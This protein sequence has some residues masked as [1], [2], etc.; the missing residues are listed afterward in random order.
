MLPIDRPVRITCDYR[1]IKELLRSTYI[2]QHKVASLRKG[3]SQY[4]KSLREIFLSYF[5]ISSLKN[6]FFCGEGM[7][8][9]NKP[10][11]RI[12]PSITISIFPA[13][14]KVEIYSA[15]DF[16]LLRRG[17]DEK[18]PHRLSKSVSCSQTT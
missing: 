2:W 17:R 6:R 16:D 5:M 12:S 10:T 9:C 14:L 8:N 11:K 3:C 4:L 15:S 18:I 1:S 13:R 7:M